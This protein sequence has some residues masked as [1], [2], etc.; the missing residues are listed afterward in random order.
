MKS[1]EKWE[2]DEVDAYLTSIDALNFK[3]ATFGMGKSGCPDRVV[4][5]NG[6]FIG[7][8][9]KRPKKEPTALQWDRIAEIQ[10]AGGIAVWGTSVK[11]IAEL[12]A[13]LFPK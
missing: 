3:P 9:V 1:P 5:Y 8:E 13:I 10:A 6:K 11:I 7:I 12:N 2:K 4:C